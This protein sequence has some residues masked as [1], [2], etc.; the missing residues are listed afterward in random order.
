[1]PIPSDGLCAF[2]QVICWLSVWLFLDAIGPSYG[3][4]AIFP[5]GLLAFLSGSLSVFSVR[6]F[7]SLFFPPVCLQFCQLDLLFVCLSFLS[8]GGMLPV[9]VAPPNRKEQYRTTYLSIKTSYSS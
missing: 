5:G 8:V 9:M 3:L 4:V 1:M 7:V 2:H 6:Q